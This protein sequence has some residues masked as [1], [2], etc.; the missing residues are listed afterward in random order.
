MVFDDA[1]GVVH[2]LIL[3]S[4]VIDIAA[5]LYKLQVTIIIIISES[6][7]CTISCN[8]QLSHLTRSRQ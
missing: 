1:V 5:K 7:Q 4:D 8:A 6:H 2:D 3:S